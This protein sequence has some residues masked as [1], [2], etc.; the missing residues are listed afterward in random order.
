MTEQEHS[1]FPG[2]VIGARTTIG[3]DRLLADGKSALVIS[4]LTIVLGYLGMVSGVVVGVA[5]ML[6][7][8]S[9]ADCSTPDCSAPH[10][11][12]AAGVGAVIGSVGVGIVIVLAGVCGRLY[13]SGRIY[14]VGAQI[15]IRPGSGTTPVTTD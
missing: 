6:Q 1:E 13:S 15:V 8:S 14:E 9:L 12:V 2:V 3:L 5:L 7:T 11:F 4:R 10:P